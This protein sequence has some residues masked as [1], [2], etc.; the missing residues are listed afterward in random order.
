MATPKIRGR[1][2]NIN[3]V[4]IALLSVVGAVWDGFD[5]QDG[6]FTMALLLWLWMPEC[7][8]YEEKMHGYL[9]KRK[10]KHLD[11]I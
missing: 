6:F 9:K 10:K 4:L 11:S 1:I 5:V 7:D 8:R 3:R 2:H